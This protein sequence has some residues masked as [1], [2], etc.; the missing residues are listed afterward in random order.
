MTEK[1]NIVGGSAAAQTLQLTVPAAII[2]FSQPPHTH[3]KH[4]DLARNWQC[5]AEI[6]NLR[7]CYGLRPP[8]RKCLAL[9]KGSSR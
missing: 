9:R 5:A 6:T 7:A 2:H 3:A 1:A 8:R 4:V